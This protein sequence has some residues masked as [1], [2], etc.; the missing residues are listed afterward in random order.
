V[1]RGRLLS[2][3]ALCALALWT[4]TSAHGAEVSGRVTGYLDDS[5]LE[6]VQILVM[7]R[8]GQAAATITASDGSYTVS[9]VDP[10]MQRVRALPPNDLNRIGAWYSDQYFFC[11]ADPLVLI[12]QEE[13]SGIDFAL[14][15]GGAIVGVV[16][17]QGVPVEGATVT[18]NGLDFFNSSLRRSAVTDAQGQFRIVGLDSIVLGG[19][20]QPGSYRL[21][22][23][24]AGEASWFYPGSFDVK[25]AGA[26]AVFRGDE[27]TADLDLGPAALLRGRVLD[28]QG[29]PVADARISLHLAGALRVQA[30]NEQGVFEFSEIVGGEV[31]V[32]VTAPGMAGLWY[33]AAAVQGA[34]ESL[35][36]QPGEELELEVSLVPESRLDL[37]IEGALDAGL[38]VV[39]VDSESGSELVATT[40]SEP[41]AP[42][43]QLSFF[44]LPARTVFVQVTPNA[45]SLLV[46]S[47]S[48]PMLLQEGQVHSVD[49]VV[50]RGGQLLATVRRRGGE[51]LRG[52]R[53]ELYAVG[54]PDRLIGSARSDG[55]G[56]LNLRGIPPGEVLVRFSLET[57]CAG[58][59]TSVPRWWPESRSIELASSV[60]VEAGGSHDL[61][62]VLLPADG[63]ADG[64]DDL[65]ELAWGLDPLLDDA[66]EDPDSD[67]LSNLEEYLSHSD[68]LR[69]AYAASGC[70]YG[71]L[72]SKGPVLVPLL[73]L[74]GICRIRGRG[75]GGQTS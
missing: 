71:G 66:Q 51:P 29:E 68:P 18:A 26:V 55:E 69:R 74:M 75:A 20:V 13:V 44:G 62:E 42:T 8:L 10:G 7:D 58:D 40:L 52:A 11:S 49:L 38:R 15:E 9:G 2:A 22:T 70:H 34:A 19:E 57:F 30:S 41:T 4:V 31:H 45:S 67:G 35:S 12:A 36:L 39:V 59:P 16:R 24:R 63:D 6:G 53:A 23:Q 72:D 28:E 3:V 17:A 43:S 56:R 61:G 65:W 32:S 64:M 47:A 27:T 46:A 48:E 54:S 60:A 5:A 73:L 37:Q 50:E 21:S 33:P 1:R 14:P 25:N